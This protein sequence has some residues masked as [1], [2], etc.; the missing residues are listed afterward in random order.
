MTSLSQICIWWPFLH[1]LFVTESPGKEEIPVLCHLAFCTSSCWGV[2]A[3]MYVKVKGQFQLLCMP[4]ILFETG[5]FCFFVH[6]CQA[7]LWASKSLLPAFHLTLG[8]LA[9]HISATTLNLMW[10]L[11][12]QTQFSS[13]LSFQGILRLSFQE[14]DWLEELLTHTSRAGVQILWP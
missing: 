1:M 14:R 4:S 10:V 11:G 13:Y 12:M 2:C 7:Y 6:C 8:V 3:H 5:L 9:L